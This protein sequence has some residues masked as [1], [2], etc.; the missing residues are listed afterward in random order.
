MSDEADAEHDKMQEL[1]DSGLAAARAAKAENQRLVED[2][3]SIPLATSPD[4]NRRRASRSKGFNE[5]QA[6]Q[7]LR[8]IN[9]K[10]VLHLRGQSHL[11][12]WDV[13]AHLTR[14]FGF[15]GWDKKI[16]SVELV[17]E[18]RVQDTVKKDKDGNPRIGWWVTYRCLMTLVIRDPQG[19]VVREIDGAATGSAENQPQR[20]EAHDL[21]LKNSVTYAL[22]VCAT[23]LGDQFGLSLYNDGQTSAVVGKVLSA[24]DADGR[25]AQAHTPDAVSE[26]TEP[27]TEEAPPPDGQDVNPFHQ[28]EKK[29]E[30]MRATP[31]D[32]QWQL[33]RPLAPPRAGP[34]TT[35]V[36]LPDGVWQPPT[37]LEWLKRMTGECATF[38]GRDGYE[39]LWRQVNEKVSS[40]GC[41]RDDGWGLKETL[42]ARWKELS[43]S[44]PPG[45][46]AGKG[47]SVAS[48]NA[49]DAAQWPEGSEGAAANKKTGAKR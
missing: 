12:G 5:K 10:R 48:G 18:D 35:D 14:I 2:W 1:S 16:R 44:E 37:D 9:G 7:L 33:P 25:D 43:E 20:G 22:K 40:G 8:P 13:K 34:N 28:P 31:A 38:T 36:P 21:A 47:D 45:P 49:A 41:T 19:N 39:S 4:V 11:A 15:E 46:P 42:R 30:R 29:A 3:E 23:D 17:F 26:D 24:A 6:K 27:G 32:D